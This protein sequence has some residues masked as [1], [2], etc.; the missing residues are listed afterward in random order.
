[1]TC[2]AGPVVIADAAAGWAAGAAWAT[3]FILCAS[4]IYVRRQVG[5]A[6]QL[7]EEQTRPFV[8]VDLEA[9]V[10]IHLTIE[11][12]GPTVA[13]NVRLEFAEPL[14]S[15]FEDPWPPEGSKL[16]SDGIPTLPPR[17][18]FRF[19]FDSF[20]ER[21]SAGL[22]MTFAVTV[23]YSGGPQDRPR[24]Y[25]DRYILDLTF[26]TGLGEVRQKGSHEIAESLEALLKEVKRWTDGT[27]GIK[28]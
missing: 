1:M 10:P 26:L 17:K 15:T 22:P 23:R 14:K 13:R 9:E 28:S 7:R 24:P 3:F 20:P 27:Q 11:N 4:L 2:E 8:V 18:R 16:L 25:E 21:L 5:E 6:R 12:V 19:F